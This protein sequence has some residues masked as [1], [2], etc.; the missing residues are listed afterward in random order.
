MSRKN[1]EDMRLLGQRFPVCVMERKAFP[2]TASR[3]IGRTCYEA[4]TVR[5]GIVPSFRNRYD[6]L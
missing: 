1:V 2:E 6:G 5:A 4:R 3:R